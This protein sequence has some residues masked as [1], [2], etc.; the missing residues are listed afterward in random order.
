MIYAAYHDVTSGNNLY[1]Q[2]TSSYDL[3][4]GIGTPNAWN[5]AQDLAG[6]SGGGG[7][8]TTQVLTN[9]G[10]ESGQSPWQESSSGGYQIV[11]TTSAHSGS[12]SAYLCGYNSCN[13]QIWQAVSIPSN[14]TT[15]QLN[16]WLYV[17]IQESGST[18][19]DYFYARLR[20][21]SGSTISTVKSLCNNTASGW[22][23]YIFDVTSTLSSY[24]GQQVQVYFQGTTD[25]SLIS[26]F[27]IDDVALNVTTP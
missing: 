21:S 26:N 9:P 16:F 8:T 20:N 25:S 19:Y 24:K 4:T 2:A 3:A 15:I 10:F 27:F 22:K 7:G 17:S 5:I 23:Q 13:D 11:D 14:A 1:Y 18:C 12:Y 6:S